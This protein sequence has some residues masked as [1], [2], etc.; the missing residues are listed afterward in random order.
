MSGRL[1]VTVNHRSVMACTSST[2]LLLEQQACGRDADHGHTGEDRVYR[3]MPTYGRQEESLSMRD[4]QRPATWRNAYRPPWP[5]ELQRAR[6]PDLHL[7]G[8][9]RDRSSHRP[10][11]RRRD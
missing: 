4:L 5:A 8:I 9:R 10:E 11:T 2:A 6:S 1:L 3:V 7:R